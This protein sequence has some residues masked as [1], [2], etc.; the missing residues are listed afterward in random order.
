MIRRHFC[1][2]RREIA[3]LRHLVKT[4][5]HHRANSFICSLHLPFVGFCDWF[6]IFQDADVVRH[7]M[8]TS[9]YFIKT[10]CCRPAKSAVATASSRGSCDWFTMWC[11]WGFPTFI[12]SRRDS[13]QAAQQLRQ[14]I[15]S[16]HGQVSCVGQSCSVA[17]TE[18]LS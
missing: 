17:P 1:V 6:T 15:C 8:D 16:A 14:S 9:L 3:A 7:K 5:F 13:L 4:S 2:V 12:F 18:L 11:D 10:A